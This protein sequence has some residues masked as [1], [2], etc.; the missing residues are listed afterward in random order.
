MNAALNAAGAKS[1]Y[2][3][4][5]QEARQDGSIQIRLN[6]ASSLVNRH[7]VQIY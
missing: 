3:L 4:Y 5:L 7:A 6:R 1:V 2:D